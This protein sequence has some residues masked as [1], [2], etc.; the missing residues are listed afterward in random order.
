M[1]NLHI[2]NVEW[3]LADKYLIDG[4]G[5]YE[6]YVDHDGYEVEM[7]CNVTKQ[8]T[9][10]PSSSNDGYQGGQYSRDNEHQV[11]YRKIA[12]QDDGNIVKIDSF[13]GVRGYQCEHVTKESE[14]ETY[15]WVAAEED[16][17]IIP[18]TAKGSGAIHTIVC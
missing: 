15:G 11:S 5:K 16:I 8:V 2:L 12:N 3:I 4:K 14:K 6:I 17:P 18:H 10:H 9:K 13:V 1:L 7:S